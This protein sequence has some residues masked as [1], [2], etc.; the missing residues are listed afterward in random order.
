M[1]VNRVLS[2][3]GVDYEYRRGHRSVRMLTDASLEV[4]PGEVVS[5]LA[6]RAQ[7]KTTLLRIAAG[8]VRPTAG[9][10]LVGGN[11][12]WTLSE[13]RRSQLLGGE[14]GWIDRSRPEVRT[15]V[16]TFVALPLMRLHGQHEAYV[17]ARDAL[18]RVGVAECADQHWEHLADWERALVALAHAIAHRPKLL[19]V[20]DLMATLGLEESEELGCLLATLAR[21]AGFSI[22]A[23]ASDASATLWSDRVASLAGGELL[24]APAQPQFGANVIELPGREGRSDSMNSA[25]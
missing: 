10:V 8:L 21:E 4:R 24:L 7:G 19:L 20:D 13:K 1:K 9:R 2:L 23:S 17:H 15:P 18:K 22:L 12:V 25:S 16:L 5:V 14:V 3:V 6:Q 11:D